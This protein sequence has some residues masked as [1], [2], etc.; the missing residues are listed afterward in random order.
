M[1]SHN[2]SD[3]KKEITTIFD[4]SQPETQ[5]QLVKASISDQKIASLNP[6]PNT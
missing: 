2:F 6:T 3:E 4:L 5:V 1:L